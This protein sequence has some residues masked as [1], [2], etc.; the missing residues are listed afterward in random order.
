MKQRFQDKF[1]GILLGLLMAALLLPSTAVVANMLSPAGQVFTGLRFFIDGVEMDVRW[2][3]AAG[4][5]HL[6]SPPGGGAVQLPRPPG[7]AP[8]RTA[9]PFVTRNPNDVNRIAFLDNA[10]LG[11]PV[12]GGVQHQN[13]LRFHRNF[14]STQ[15]TLHDL[16]GNHARLSGHLGRIGEQT[17]NATVRFIG[18]GV[19]L[20]TIDIVAVQSN[21]PLPFSVNVAGVNRLRIEI[22]FGNA[23]ARS[24]LGIAAFLE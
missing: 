16:H 8:L 9:A 13:V 15:Y 17:Y 18:D 7:G 21:E 14:N 4:A 1:K 10:V 20:H 6:T 23:N 5:V 12:F 2:D 11:D 24:T 3:E 19:V 22:L